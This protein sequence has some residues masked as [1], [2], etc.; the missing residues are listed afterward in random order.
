LPGAV[1]I[2][3]RNGGF[4]VIDRNDGHGLSLPGGMA[5]LHEEPLG[6]LR[7]EVEEETGLNVSSATLL[8]NYRD[9]SIFPAQIF[10]FEADAV[11][12]LHGSWEG[13]PV[14]ASLDDLRQRIIRSQRRVVQWL[15]NG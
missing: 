12:E 5:H 15:E 14:V 1:A 11:G 3:R 7:R 8:F 4:L 6:T 13:E 2:I 9:D 10:V